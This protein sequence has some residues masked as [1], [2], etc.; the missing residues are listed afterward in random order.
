M[1]GFEEPKTMTD[2]YLLMLEGE[3]FDRVVSAAHGEAHES[4]MS[5]LSNTSASGA[6]ACR[7]GPEDRG[8]KSTCLAKSLFMQCRFFHHQNEPSR[9]DKPFA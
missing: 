8:K 5:I 1:K 2:T 9:Q 4:F 7:S 3:R 6:I